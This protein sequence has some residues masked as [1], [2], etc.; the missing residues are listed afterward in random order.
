MI[1][2][3]GITVF[4]PYRDLARGNVFTRLVCGPSFSR[5]GT[6]TENRDPITAITKHH[7]HQHPTFLLPLHH[8]PTSTPRKNGE[9]MN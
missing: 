5:R 4:I 3:S 7:S 1:Y 6:E 2:T 8:K 9:N